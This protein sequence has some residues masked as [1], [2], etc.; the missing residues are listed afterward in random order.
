MR[1]KRFHSLNWAFINLVWCFLTP[2]GFTA[3]K[4][5]RI[6]FE[7]IKWLTATKDFNICLLLH[8][9]LPLKHWAFQ[10]HLLVV[11]GRI[12]R[13]NDL[14]LLLQLISLEISIEFQMTIIN[15]HT[16]F[17]GM[18]FFF[19]LALT[20]CIQH[21]YCFWYVCTKRWLLF[22]LSNSIKFYFNC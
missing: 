22:I 6:M 8:I 16:L 21:F 19:L 2:S 7:A 15:C 3:A 10:L 20:A 12:I 11:K 5:W 9:L 1:I 4:W 17:S 18:N 13:C 14:V